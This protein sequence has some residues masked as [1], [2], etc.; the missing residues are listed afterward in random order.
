MGEDVEK[1]KRELL[2]RLGLLGMVTSVQLTE[3]ANPTK[4]LNV[5]FVG[6][7][8]FARRI[9]DEGAQALVRDGLSPELAER[10][11]KGVREAGS[12]QCHVTLDH[13][14]DGFIPRVVLL[15]DTGA[16]TPDLFRLR[17]MTSALIGIFGIRREAQQNTS[18][19][20][21]LVALQKIYSIPTDAP[22]GALTLPRVE[23]ALR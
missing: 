15:V 1:L 23:E 19:V 2:P 9:R 22:F 21:Q 20:S 7:R 12:T 14:E 18:E 17:C 10:L 3:A 13:D 8:S 16:E 6:S 11:A 5:G 4:E